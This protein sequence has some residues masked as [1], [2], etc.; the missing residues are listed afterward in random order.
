[1]D[2]KRQSGEKSLSP[3]KTNGGG[4][5]DFVLEKHI[6][7]NVFEKDIRRVFMYK[8]AERLSKAI[9][10][11]APAFA[12]TPSLKDRAETVA[13]TIIDA[14][15]MVPAQ[16]RASLS[17]E[18]LA[19]SSLLAIG[20]TSGI[21]SPMNADIIAREA[22][23][24]LQEVAA[25][26]EPRILMEE[27][28]SFAELAKLAGTAPRRAGA[29]IGETA[30]SKPRAKSPTV[31]GHSKGQ[32]VSDTGPSPRREAVISVLRSKGPSYIKDIS[33]IVRDVS[34]KTIQRELQALVTEGV[35]HKQGERRWTVYSLPG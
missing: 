32:T 19:L 35:V 23:N 22:H 21:L 7:S 30:P 29:A 25:Y 11:I 14:S 28:P 34:E 13:I 5:E 9:H 26:E 6:F 10:L 12:G 4:F 18:L 2:D 20:R 27:M 8:K 16:A 31:K 24:L 17:R 3:K 33:T 1:M 15:I